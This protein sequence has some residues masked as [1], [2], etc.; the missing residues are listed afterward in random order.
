MSCS[1]A[2]L[3]A[4]PSE[5][6][7]R[8]ASSAR[9]RAVRTVLGLGLLIL[10]G[11]LIVLAAQDIGQFLGWDPFAR[12]RY[13][14]TRP[15]TGRST[16]LPQVRPLKSQAAQHIYGRSSEC[17]G[18]LMPSTTFRYDTGYLG[19]RSAFAIDP[20]LTLSTGTQHVNGLPGALQDS[21]PDRWGHNLITKQQRH[22]TLVAGRRAAS[23]SDTD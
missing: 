23:L 11:R 2:G 20:D 9:P 16:R 13:R 10:A 15:A 17:R 4:V 8:L 12:T 7:S 1:S 5:L 6:G 21:A 19:Q 22:A 3:S 14:A 18:E